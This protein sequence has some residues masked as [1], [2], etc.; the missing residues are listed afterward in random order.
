MKADQVDAGWTGEPV[1][2]EDL[3]VSLPLAEGMCWV[4]GIA[5]RR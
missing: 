4:I 2:N 3:F 1:S 5:C